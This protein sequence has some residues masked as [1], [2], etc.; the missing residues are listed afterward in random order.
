VGTSVHIHERKF[1]SQFVDIK[2]LIK[3]DLAIRII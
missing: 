1:L 3:L 2:V